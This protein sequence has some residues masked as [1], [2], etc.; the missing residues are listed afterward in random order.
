MFGGAT[1]LDIAVH[2]WIAFFLFWGIQVFIILK[3]IEGIK[4]LETWSAP[5][6]LGGGL[7]LLVW[8]SWRRRRFGPC[9][10]GIGGLAKTAE[11]LLGYFPG[12]PDRFGRLLGDAESEHS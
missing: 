4:H 5:L 12:R 8:A 11:Q 2:T 6:L 10:D 3:G 7:I 9:F 1:V